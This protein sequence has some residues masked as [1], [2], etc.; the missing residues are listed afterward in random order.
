MPEV[1]APGIVSKGHSERSV[2]FSPGQD[3]LFYE[4]RCLG[5]ETVLIR[6]TQ[7]EEGWSRPETASFSGIPEYSD[8][9]P[10]FSSDGRRL[11]FASNRPV[12]PGG[13]VKKD[14]DIWM[15]T[16]T[17]GAW[18][19][20]I[21]A[22]SVLNS[23]FHDEYPTL[24]ESNNLYFSS[25]RSGNSDIYMAHF[26]EEGFS[27]PQR[28]KGPVNTGEYEG[29][30]FIAADESYL[31]F[32][33]DRPGQLGEGDFYISFKGDDGEWSEPV[34]LGKGINSP[35]HEA[36]P[37]VSSDGQFLFFCSFRT[38]PGP[39]AARLSYPRIVELLDGPENGSG[40]IY[41]VSARFL[42]DLRPKER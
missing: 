1:F 2:V 23:D 3:E 33:A 8:R 31:I 17:N 7:T 18:G 36:A 13:G 28:L 38:K 29:H 37:C 39:S 22:G 32:L 5:F 24:S 19:E 27:E 42:K 41:W 6:M 14:A 34:S 21:H 25:D 16:K 35:A 20:P 12:S 11:F 4:L 26:T 40:D 9:S 30:A 15:V 10:F